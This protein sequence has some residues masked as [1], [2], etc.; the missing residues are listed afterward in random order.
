MWSTWSLSFISACSSWSPAQIRLSADF[1]GIAFTV[2]PKA[3]A[4]FP[5]VSAASIAAKVT[6]DEETKNLPLPA[7]LPISREFGS[8]YPGEKDA[9]TSSVSWA[10]RLE[11]SSNHPCLDRAVQ[12][13]PTRKSGW[14]H[15]STQCLAFPPLCAFHGPRARLFSPQ[16]TRWR[17][18]GRSM[19][20]KEMP[21][22]AKS[23]LA[24]KRRFNP[25][26]IPFSGPAN[27]SEFARAF[28]VLT[29]RHRTARCTDSV[30]V[31]KV[32]A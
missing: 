25:L 15:P 8:G 30:F 24:P 17:L 5:I 20:K 12:L 29:S 21:A 2:C 16:P 1:P 13:T 32:I 7:G 22:K 4:L 9:R 14:N 6:R 26:A 3:D 28:A 11:H 10:S 27:S 23:P 31:T 19:L 18:R